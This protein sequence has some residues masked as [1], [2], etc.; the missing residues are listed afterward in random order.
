MF[1]ESGTT[2]RWTNE[3]EDAHT[4]TGDNGG[5]NSGQIQENGTYSYTFNTPGTY[6]YH[7]ANHPE[8]EGVVVV[9]P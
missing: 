7:C 5:P 4:V 8:M 3:D 6:P 2:V 9:T 1:V